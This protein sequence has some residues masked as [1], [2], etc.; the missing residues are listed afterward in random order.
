MKKIFAA[1]IILT[2]TAA[3][4]Q[5]KK[6]DKSKI[7]DGYGTLKWG[8]LL[9]DVKK[10]ITGKLSYTDDKSVIV[11]RDGE[12][13][14]YY[15]FFYIDP[16]AVPADKKEAA[17]P[18]PQPAPKPAADDKKDEGKLFY[19]ALKF[20]YLSREAVLEKV[21]KEYGK[22]TSENIINDQG[23]MAWDSENTIIIVW[24]DRYEKKQFSRRITYISKKIA[25][26][27]NDYQKS[28]FNKTELDLIK[29]LKP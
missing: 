1:I 23:A 20:P 14:Y 2:V 4:S 10:D 18:A 15:G 29:N 11:S 7:P 25:S 26:E 22:P 19:V 24:I 27:L 16:A 21:E 9:S 3:V 17:Q 12:L 5:E 28:V 8:A 6:G 13:E